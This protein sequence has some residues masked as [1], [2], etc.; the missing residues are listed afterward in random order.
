MLLSVI[1]PEIHKLE[2][3]QVSQLMPG[4][5]SHATVNCIAVEGSLTAHN[6]EVIVADR[7]LINAKGDSHHQLTNV[8]GIDKKGKK[9]RK[10]R[11]CA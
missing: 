9:H 11:E 4:E 1:D 6:P 2:W 3:L 8:I 10:T 7:V 5:L